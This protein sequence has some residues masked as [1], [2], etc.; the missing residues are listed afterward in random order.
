MSNEITTNENAK[1]PTKSTGNVF[2]DMGFPKE[3]AVILQLKTDMKIEIEAFNQLMLVQ[4]IE[5]E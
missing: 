2:E 3:E 1:K 4:E 5:D